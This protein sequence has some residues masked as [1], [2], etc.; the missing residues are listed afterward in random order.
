MR[1]WDREK[2]VEKSVTEGLTPIGPAPDKA[3]MII[4]DEKKLSYSIHNPV[5]G[6]TTPILDRKTKIISITGRFMVCVKSSPDGT[7]TVYRTEI[8]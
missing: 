8:K 4:G 3:G 7:K 2:L 6:K 1:V 5:S